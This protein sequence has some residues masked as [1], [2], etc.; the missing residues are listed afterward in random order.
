VNADQYCLLDAGIPA[1]NAAHRGE[2]YAVCDGVSS[3]EEGAWA[4]SLTCERL[5]QFFD[6]AGTPSKEVLVQLVGEI[7]WE[8]RGHGRGR[9]ACTLTALWFEGVRAHLLHIGDSCAL[10]LRDGEMESITPNDAGSGR[11]LDAYMGMGAEVATSL[12]VETFTVVRGDVYFILTDGVTDLLDGDALFRVWRR[13]GNPQRC[14]RQ[15]VEL[16]DDLGGTDDA[17][18]LVIEVIQ[19]DAAVGSQS[20]R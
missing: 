11:R 9:G 4:A 18:A 10:R 3:V 17:T 16:V 14:A 1:V 20:A 15:L 12:H 7:D 19:V 8:I 2:L 5:F 13:T 6:P